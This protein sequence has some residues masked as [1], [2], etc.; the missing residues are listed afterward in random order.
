MK[1]E[2]KRIFALLVIAAAALA[3]AGCATT[4]AE[5][6]SPPP[7][8]QSAE[9]ANEE[10]QSTK[11]AVGVRTPRHVRV[12]LLTARQMLEGVGGYQAD[13][14]AVIV[15]GE[16]VESLVAGG[17]LDEDVQHTLEAGD[18]RVV[19][20]GLTVDRMDIDPDRLITGVEVVPNGIIELARL[21]SLGFESVE[22]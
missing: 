17:E 16:G 12:G 4:T 21:Q 9:P 5:A 20:C 3:A 6:G 22:L 8:S 15:C 19:V 2:K 18:V 14:V 7:A 13:E 11:A 10:V 1:L